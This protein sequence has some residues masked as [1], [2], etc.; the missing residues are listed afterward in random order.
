VDDQ[1]LAALR[2][3]HTAE[4]RE[5]RRRAREAGQEFADDLDLG[6]EMDAGAPMPHVFA[7]GTACSC[8]STCAPGSPPAT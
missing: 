7:N 4:L 2:E 8:S 3:R 1:E 6:I 5:E